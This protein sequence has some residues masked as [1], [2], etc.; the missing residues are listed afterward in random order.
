MISGVLGRGVD[1]VHPK[2]TDL[3]NLAKSKMWHYK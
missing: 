2:G 3:Y 1:G